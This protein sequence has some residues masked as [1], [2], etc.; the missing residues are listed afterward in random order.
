MLIPPGPL[1]GPKVN[2]NYAN[3]CNTVQAKYHT[4]PVKPSTWVRLKD[5]K[6]GDATYDE[7]LNQLMDALP[8]EKVSKRFLAEHDRRLKE[9]QGSEWRAA[10]GR[11]GDA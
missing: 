1:A 5:Y 11:L 8:L 6:M 9:F 2:Y 7:V 10:R 4:I 3:Q